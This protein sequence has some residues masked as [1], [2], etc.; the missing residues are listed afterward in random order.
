MDDE[1]LH[2]PYRFEGTAVPGVGGAGG[3]EHL[4]GEL[5]W[6]AAEARLREVDVAL[7]PVGAVEQHGPHLPLDTDAHDAW[8]LACRVAEACSEPRPLVLPLMPYGV[9]YHHDDFPGT[10]SVSNEALSQVVYDV[11][12]SCARC[13]I[14]KLVIVNGHGGNSA[15]L[16]YAAQMINRD[17]HI[18]TCVDTGETS[19][20]DLAE[21]CDTPNDVHA[22]EAE[23]STSLATR[24]R[25]V[26][27]EAAEA[28]VPEFSSRYL[29]FSARRSVEW[30][31]RTR[32]ISP[33]GVLGDPTKAT[34]AKG[35][36]MW[37]LMIRNLVE[38]VE[39][40]KSLPLDEIYERR[41]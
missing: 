36:R 20:V 21:L 4:L 17:A 7:L 32:R 35:E 34:A 31:A 10:I 5:S 18:F 28:F 22:G 6:P 41:Y 9:S 24:P 27:M 25:L 30:Y 3:H 1:S 19:D 37:E 15:T 14:T 26:H 23:T 11:G 13:G 8:Y 16:E 38:L 2:S 39:H 12:M 40:L 33:S 29:D